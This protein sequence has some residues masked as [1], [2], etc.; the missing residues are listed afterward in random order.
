[1]EYIIPP[2]LEQKIKECM[3]TPQEQRVLLGRIADKLLDI[4]SARIQNGLNAAGGPLLDGAQD[5]YTPAY[6]AKKQGRSQRGYKSKNA[7]AKK[8]GADQFVGPTRG[9][10][11]PGTILIYSGKMMNSR[12]VEMRSN[13]LVEIVFSPEEQSKA[14][15]NNAR[16]EFVSTNL[17]EV[18]QAV[19]SAIQELKGA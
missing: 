7:K 4:V 19:L 18:N 2:D 17:D 6:E 5:R 11:A 3:F 13:S 15:A 9:V 10:Y 8:A 16:R 1:M 14:A 12:H